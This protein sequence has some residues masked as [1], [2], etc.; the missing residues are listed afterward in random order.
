[1]AKQTFAAKTFAARTFSCATW[2]GPR[3]VRGPLFAPEAAAQVVL[4]G[5]TVGEAV[6][7]GRVVATAR[8]WRWKRRRRKRR[9][10]A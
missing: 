5:G 7:G 8:P 2:A 10:A 3:R 9:R 6:P 4:D 1:M